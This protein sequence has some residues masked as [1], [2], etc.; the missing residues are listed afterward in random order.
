MSSR[1]VELWQLTLA[2]LREFY[3]EPGAVFWVFGFPVLLAVGLGIAF[4]NQPPERP[5]VAIVNGPEAAF[6]A[7][8]LRA[9]DVA[10]V[11]LVSDD[12]AARQ[13]RTGEVALTL[14]VPERAE[15]RFRLD[16][17]REEARHARDRVEAALQ[18]ALGRVDPA[19]VVEAQ[20][21]EPG[22]RYID[23][24]LPGLIGLNLMGSSM[25]GIGYAVV[26]ARRRRLLKRLAATPMR[27]SSFMLAFVLS[28]LVFLVVEVAALLLFGA[29]VFDVTV[30]G[31]LVAVAGISV[32]GAAA[33]TGIA[34]AV[35]ARVQSIEAVSGWM[36]LIM[37]PMWLLSGTFFSYARFPEV[38]QPFI[39]ALP[40]TAINDALRAVMSRGAPVHSVALEL[41]VLAAFALLGMAWAL[42]TFRWQ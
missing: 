1:R 33:F 36:N 12:E 41:G 14:A 24:L 35:A 19:R 37:L 30:H 9:G 18:R 26:D 4:R 40:L 10:E 13:L 38:V 28:R 22:A 20:V 39:R 3:R 34:L 6:A 42:R 31:S 25:W 11:V 16:P 8:V 23:F 32:L 2:R 5:R 21:T 7:D 29:L 15:L 17:T 27:R